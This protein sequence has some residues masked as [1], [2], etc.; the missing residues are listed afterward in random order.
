M[1]E[2]GYKIEKLINKKTYHI[3]ELADACKVAKEVTKKG[4]ICLLSP[5]A[6]SYNKFKNFE[7]KGNYFQKYVKGE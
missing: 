1:P 6:S 7:E 4:A 5:S 3:E 2:T